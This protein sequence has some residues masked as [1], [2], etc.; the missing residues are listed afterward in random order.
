VLL[1]NLFYRFG[2]PP[3]VDW[4]AGFDDALT[5]QRQVAPKVNY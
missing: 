2:K 3:M 5:K 1:P 4:A